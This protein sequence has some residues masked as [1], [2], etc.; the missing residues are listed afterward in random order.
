M[1]ASSA[2]K[3][4]HSKGH[5][6]RSFTRP[7]RPPAQHPGGGERARRRRETAAAPGFSLRALREGW[8]N[9]TAVVLL[10]V[11]ST[12]AV[13]DNMHPTCADRNG[14]IPRE[15]VD[16]IVAA[17]E[18]SGVSPSVI[19]AQLHTESGWDADAYSPAGARGIAQF[20]PET[21]ETYGDGDITDPEASIRAQGYYL[22][23]LRSMIAELEPA[24]K[25]KETELVLASYNAGPTVVLEQKGVPNYPETQ[26]YIAQINELAGTRYANVCAAQ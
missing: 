13:I 22:K 17:S 6:L 3:P 24:D 2:R 8:I 20:M 1:P 14:A 21:W 11:G 10:A 25:Q 16:D 5:T 19:A 9:L 4:R 23:D 12:G 7:R 18:V 15:W 26:K